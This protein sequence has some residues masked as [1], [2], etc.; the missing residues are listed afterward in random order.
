VA[1]VS[2]VPVDEGYGSLY[3]ETS[4]VDGL[5]SRI[6]DAENETKKLNSRF[7][8]EREHAQ[9][10]QAELADRNMELSAKFRELERCHWQLLQRDEEHQ[11]LAAAY[12]KLWS[13]NASLRAE[14]EATNADRDAS[15]A[16]LA[17]V[18]DSTSW[19]LTGP[20]REVVGRLRRRPFASRR[21]EDA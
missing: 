11:T 18:L 19:Q 12:Q 21:S 6:G 2:D 1:V 16:R 13:E 15:N 17:A 7:M 4:S 10:I 8:E 20:L 14:R 5:F 3:I 9:R